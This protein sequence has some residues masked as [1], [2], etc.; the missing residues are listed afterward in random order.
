MLDSNVHVLFSDNT[1]LANKDDVIVSSSFNIQVFVTRE[2]AGPEK[3]FPMRYGKR[4]EL[5]EI[6]QWGPNTLA[7][8]CG[9]EPMLNQ[10]LSS[11][12]DGFVTFDSVGVVLIQV[13]ALAVTNG[14]TFHKETFEL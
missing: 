5:S 7:F 12:I 6:M 3:K 10:V 14:F 9:P 4:P 1:Q 2:K 11:L 13:Q 8:A